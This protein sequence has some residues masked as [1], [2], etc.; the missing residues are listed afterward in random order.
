[1]KWTKDEIDY[2]YE[3]YGKISTLEISKYIG[4]AV[5]SIR[6]KA[7]ELNIRIKSK[8][9]YWTDDEIDFLKKILSK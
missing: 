1:M 6:W 7:N 5:G 3:N 2:L 8:K 4:R 9:N